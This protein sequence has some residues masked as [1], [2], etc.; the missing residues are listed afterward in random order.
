M[1][2]LASPNAVKNVLGV[3][4]FGQNL[5]GKIVYGGPEKLPDLKGS[6]L[7]LNIFCFFSSYLENLRKHFWPEGFV[8]LSLGVTGGGHKYVSRTSQLIDW[9]GLRG[10]FSDMP[11]ELFAGD[12]PFKMCKFLSCLCGAVCQG[13]AQFGAGTTSIYSLSK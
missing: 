8:P 7:M 9:I 6:F 13:M 10:Q 2:P 11:N 12:C 4:F 1:Q 3:T 5:F